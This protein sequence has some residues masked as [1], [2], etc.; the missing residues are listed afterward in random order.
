MTDL[1]V[2]CRDCSK[3]FPSGELQDLRC[4]GCRVHRGCEAERDAIS[5]YVKKQARYSAAG[6][7][8]NPKQLLA[9]KRH[10]FARVASLVP[11]PRQGMV[12]AEKEY[13]LAVK[14]TNRFRVSPEEAGAL[15][16]K[17][18]KTLLPA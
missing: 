14:Q 4:I 5:A 11:D 15:R 17:V 8:A 16:R 7:I 12:L 10:L 3:P 6:A 9:L 1:I 2:A 18:L 13:D